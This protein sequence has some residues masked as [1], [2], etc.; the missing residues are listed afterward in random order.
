MALL[1]REPTIPYFQEKNKMKVCMYSIDCV[2]NK[3]TGGVRRFLELMDALRKTGHDVFLYSADSTEIIQENGLRGHSILNSSQNKNRAMV[4]LKSAFGNWELFKEIKNECFDRVVVFDIRAAFS[5]VINGVKNI[6]LF[7]RQDM[8][9]YKEIQ[10]EDSGVGFIKKIVLLNIA[11]LTEGLCLKQ[12]DK[13]IV[14]CQFDLDGILKRHPMQRGKIMHKS[15]IQ[16]NNINPSWILAGGGNIQQHKDYDVSFIGNFKDYRK[17][18]DLLLPALK[19][20]ADEGVVLRVAI[21]GDGKHLE[22]CI[23]QYSKYS[24][25]E[26]LGRLDNPIPIV[27]NSRLLI[28]PSYVDSCPNTVLEGLYY[29]VPVIGANRSGIPEILNNPEWLFEMDVASIK[30]KIKNSLE[31]Q[32]NAIL[33]EQ[34]LLRREELMFD[35]GKIMADIVTA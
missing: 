2:F 20:L 25:I 5:L 34:Q 8:Y 17:G 13:I 28:V 6:N 7:L 31:R 27:E 21:I 15:R 18:Y 22:E 24:N 29:K 14:Q 16:I 12:A 1:L 4:G 23:K 32:M 30:E 11:K 10:M 33:Q 26:F 19:E 3:G 9:L 35:W